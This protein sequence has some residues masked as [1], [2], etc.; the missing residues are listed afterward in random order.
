MATVTRVEFTDEINGRPLDSDGLIV[1]NWS[2][3]GVQYVRHQRSKSRPYRERSG[4]HGDFAGGLA[5]SRGRKRPPASTSAASASKRS[6]AADTKAIRAWARREVDRVSVTVTQ[7]S[8]DSGEQVS[9]GLLA[10]T[11]PLGADAAVLVM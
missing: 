11:A 5:P 4:A 9:A 3:L 6:G 7:R 10:V 8:A 1:V 2:W